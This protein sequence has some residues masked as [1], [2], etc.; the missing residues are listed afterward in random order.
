VKERQHL[1]G[2]LP[3]SYIKQFA[4]IPYLPFASQSLRPCVKDFPKE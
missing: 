1:A 3:V 2:N 4:F